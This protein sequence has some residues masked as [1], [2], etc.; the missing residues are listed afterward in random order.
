M[1]TRWLT[2]RRTVCLGEAFFSLG[3]FMSCAIVMRSDTGPGF[4]DD[5]TIYG[6]T[7]KDSGCNEEDN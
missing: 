6:S 4:N 7:D 1:R 3:C 5:Q 2:L